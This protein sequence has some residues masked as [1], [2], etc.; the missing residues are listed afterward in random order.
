VTRRRRPPV[1]VAVLVLVL[2]A[3]LT[4]C[5]DPTE[6]ARPDCDDA[7]RLAVIAQ[8]VPEAAYVPCVAT[9]PAGWSFAGLDVTDAGTTIHLE[10]DRS[11]R[12]V[13]IQ[14]RDGCD[15]DAATPIA[16]RDQGVRTHHLVESVDPR[17]S[18][19]F[20]DAFP[21]GCVVSSYDFE[22]GRHVPLVAEL[23]EAVGLRSRLELRQELRSRFGITLDP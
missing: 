3:A 7:G 16:P 4:S 5:A 11:D 1:T 8:S 6:V 19:R 12:G 2:A 21:G 13:R 14:L 22:R 10:S 9:L 17:F 18:G 20:L 23:Q 15:T